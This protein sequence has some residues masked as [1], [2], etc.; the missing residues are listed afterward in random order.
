M[1]WAAEPSKDKMERQGP[2]PTNTLPGGLAAWADCH[3]RDAAAGDPGESSS[4]SNAGRPRP[5]LPPLPL[6]PALKLRLFPLVPARVALQ[7][8]CSHACALPAKD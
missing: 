2:E 1:K 3:L 8:H 5:G 7:L 4:K 6:G